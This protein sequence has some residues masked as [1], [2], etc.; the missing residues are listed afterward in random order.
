L[1]CSAF[2]L[3]LIGVFGIVLFGAKSETLERIWRQHISTVKFAM[4]VLFLVL[5][6]VLITIVM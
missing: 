2:V 6:A 3:P 5:S 1:Y 4:G